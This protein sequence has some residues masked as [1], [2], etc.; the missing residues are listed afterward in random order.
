MSEDGQSLTKKHGVKFYTKTDEDLEI[1]FE[2]NKKI[3]KSLAPEHKLPESI[4]E[5]AGKLIIENIRTIKLIQIENIPDDIKSERLKY[6]EKH[7]QLL[8]EWLDNLE[9]NDS[10]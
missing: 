9:S 1:E 10:D 8:L 5:Y 2:S 3:N 6:L 7:Q 4:T